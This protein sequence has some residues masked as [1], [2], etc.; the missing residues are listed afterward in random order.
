MARAVVEVEG[1]RELRRTMKAAGE[2][3]GDLKDANAEV[4]AYVAAAARGAAPSVSGRL[5]GSVRGNRAA[6]SAVV[7]AGGA[8]V[9]YAGP[10]HW[11]W[12]SRNIAAHPFVADT[13]AETEPHWTETYREAVQRILDRI[14]G[15]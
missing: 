13:A 9:P 5:A 4:A 2:D 7:K 3:L 6:A 8:A 15:K 12:P 11:G 10:I 14:K 1:A